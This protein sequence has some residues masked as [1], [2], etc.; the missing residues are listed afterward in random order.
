MGIILP[1]K[2]GI[3]IQAAG[4]LQV[5]GFDGVILFKSISIP[6]KQPKKSHPKITLETKILVVIL[7]ELH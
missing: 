5:V 6:T 7:N 3:W 2:I 4:D 1:K